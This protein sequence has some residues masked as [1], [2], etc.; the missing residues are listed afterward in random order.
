[1]LHLALVL[2]SVTLAAE[3][4][5]KRKAYSQSVLPALTYGSETWHLTKNQDIKLGSTQRGMERKMLVIMLR[6][7]KHAMWIREQTKVD[8][9]TTIKK[10][11]TWVGHM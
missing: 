9:L 2:I 4:S 1:M 6:D 7:R 8:V 10:K 3:S 5:L 11:I